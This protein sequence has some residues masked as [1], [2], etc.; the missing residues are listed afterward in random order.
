MREWIVREQDLLWDR[1]D[2]AF[3]QSLP[4]QGSWSMEAVH[5]AVRIVEAARL[6]G[7]T[8]RGEQP[9]VLERSGLRDALLNLGGVPFEPVDPADRARG[10]ELM[11]RPQSAP[12]K[13]PGVM[14]PRGHW[15]PGYDVRAGG[16][17]STELPD[18]WARTVAPLLLWDPPWQSAGGRTWYELVGDLWPDRSEDNPLMRCAVC[19]QAYLHSAE[20]QHPAHTLRGVS[21]ADFLEGLT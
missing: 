3:R 13:G 19:G 1:L 4:E 14:E 12:Q 5:V 6:V 2:K 17:P 20:S 18:R 7:P 16:C 21:L 8:A 9:H 15:Y 10:D 11:D